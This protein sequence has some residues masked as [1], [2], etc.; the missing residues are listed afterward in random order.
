MH[1]GRNNP[2]HHS[3]MRPFVPRVVGEVEDIAR[4]SKTV[5]TTA[6]DNPWTLQRAGALMSHPREES[7]YRT[8]WRPLCTEQSY[9]RVE[10]TEV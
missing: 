10:F 2:P 6:A 5:E 9:G 3:W 7:L 8:R 1:C 4:S